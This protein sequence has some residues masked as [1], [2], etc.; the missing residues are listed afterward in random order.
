MFHIIGRANRRRYAPQLQLMYDLRT[1]IF[2][3]RAHGGP[4]AVA[5][6]GLQEAFDDDDALYLIRFDSFG[7]IV[8]SARLRSTA[9]TSLITAHYPHAI[10]PG[11]APINAPDAWEFSHYYARDSA[12]ESAGDMLRAEMRLAV[13]A[14]ALDAGV[15]RIMTVTEV[16]R[17]GAIRESGWNFRELGPL[18]LYADD[19]YAVA[20]EISAQVEDLAVFRMR[21]D[22]ELRAS[23]GGDDT[24]G[25][26]TGLADRLGSQAL[27]LV[28][29]VSRQLAKVEEV[30]GPEAALALAEGLERALRRQ[31][32]S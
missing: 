15:S 13:L 26:L 8:C 10:A 12:S 17:A 23:V 4:E 22:E 18:F 32:P 16:E 24:L 9:R 25:N 6:V 30:E 21:L 3:G 19:A 7:E 1:T 29:S 27:S 31:R 14:A 28:N 2:E 11:G 20:F 5:G